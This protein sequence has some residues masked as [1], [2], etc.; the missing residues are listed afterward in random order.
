M[1]HAIIQP[2]AKIEKKVKR[3]TITGA[4]T[5]E[6]WNFQVRWNDN[7]T[8]T[9]VTGRDKVVQLHECCDESLRKDPTRTV[10]SGTADKSEEDVMKFSL[11]L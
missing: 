7:V 4:G 9:K 5:S 11:R 6:D 8:A 10:G 3:P 1:T 2:R